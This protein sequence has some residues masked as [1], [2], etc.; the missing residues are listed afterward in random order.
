MSLLLFYFF[1]VTS[2]NNFRD[3]TISLVLQ[4]NSMSYK[5]HDSNIIDNN[6]FFYNVYYNSK[7]RYFTKV[8]MIYILQTIPISIKY[9]SYNL[10]NL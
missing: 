8:K 9:H 5:I 6:L 7:Y 2:I 4:N 1:N 10:Y 3:I